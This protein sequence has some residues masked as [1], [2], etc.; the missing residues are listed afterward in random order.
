MDLH[1]DK[2]RRHT[3]E[4]T[5]TEPDLAQCRLV[6]GT[7]Y[8]TAQIVIGPVHRTLERKWIKFTAA[9]DSEEQEIVFT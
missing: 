5:R 4:L 7:V 3:A 2:L 8:P 6:G 1:L 9:L